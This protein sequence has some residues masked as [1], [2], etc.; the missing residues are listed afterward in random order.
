MTCEECKV[1]MRCVNDGDRIGTAKWVPCGRDTFYDAKHSF[2]D[3][4][5]GSVVGDV[6]YGCRKS[7][8]K[9]TDDCH[10]PRRER[11]ECLT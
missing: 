10:S 5:N 9:N 8:C 6:C 11:S 3:R 1:T 2:C 4:E 7:V